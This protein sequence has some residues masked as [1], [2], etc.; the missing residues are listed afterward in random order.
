MKPEE[1]FTIHQDSPDMEEINLRFTYHSP[2]ASQ[3]TT[4]TNFR[5]KARALAME[6]VTT[7]PPCREASLALTKL[8]ECVMHFNSGIMRR[9]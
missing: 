9:D 5:V 8:E 4:M 3:I 6:I 2:D 7:M 1:I